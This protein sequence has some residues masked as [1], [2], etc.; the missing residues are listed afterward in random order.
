MTSSGPLVLCLLTLVHCGLCVRIFPRDGETVLLTR[1]FS[2]KPSSLVPVPIPIRK[3]AN[4]IAVPLS[5]P[6]EFA[7]K[8]TKTL[9]PGTLGML[10]DQVTCAAE[11]S[12]EQIN[13]E[14]T[15]TTTMPAA[16]KVSNIKLHISTT[17]AVFGAIAPTRV[18]PTPLFVTAPVERR[19]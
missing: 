8:P 13:I 10:E 11:R 12:Y 4:T 16:T 17:A 15:A 19:G 7:I 9:A 2:V 1:E 18:L 3:T 14:P 5:V 6:R